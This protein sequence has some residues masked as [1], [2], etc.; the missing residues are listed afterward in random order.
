[1]LK[2]LGAAKFS[3]QKRQIQSGESF[4]SSAQQNELSFRHNVL[5]F[6]QMRPVN[7]RGVLCGQSATLLQ[8][9]L[10]PVR[11]DHAMVSWSAA[12]PIG[13]YTNDNIFNWLSSI[14]GQEGD[15]VLAT[16]NSDELR[17]ALEN[18]L[19]LTLFIS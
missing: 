16:R 17:H 6:G 1:M 12:T 14:G 7:V 18:K 3:S 11:N 5:C 15:V 2:A 19:F 9:F 13:A 4:F 8:Q 10:L